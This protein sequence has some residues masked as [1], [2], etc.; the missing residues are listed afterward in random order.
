MSR[1]SKAILKQAVAL[2]YT[3]DDATPMGAYRDAVTDLLH[4]AYAR[5]VHPAGGSTAK[6][7]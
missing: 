6:R 3:E 4:L 2:Y 7:L 1:K 5:K